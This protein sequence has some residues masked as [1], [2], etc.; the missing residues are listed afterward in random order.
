MAVA[1]PCLLQGSPVS[2]HTCRLSPSG[3]AAALT[4]DGRGS[5]EG[6]HPLVSS[7]AGDRWLSALAGAFRYSFPHVA[8]SPSGRYL[9]AVR[10]PGDDG[11]HHTHDACSSS[12]ISVLVFDAS[13]A[14]WLPQVQVHALGTTS[15]GG[16]AEPIGPLIWSCPGPPIFSPCETLVATQVI[17]QPEHDGLVFSLL[18]VGVHHAF[19][20]VLVSDR[21]LQHKWLPGP[22]P[23]PSLV[24]L[25]CETGALARADL[26]MHATASTGQPLEVDWHPPACTRQDSVAFDVTL[27]TIVLLQV[28]DCGSEAAELTFSVY[29]PDLQQH[30]STGAITVKLQGALGAELLTLGDV[31]GLSLDVGLSCSVHL[32]P[33]AVAA[34]CWDQEPQGP[35]HVYVFGLN[36]KAG[37]V[38]RHLFSAQGPEVEQMSLSFS[39]GGHFLAIT[40]VDAVCVLDA[41]TGA[42]LQRLQPCDFSTSLVLHRHVA[43]AG[44]HGD[45]LHVVA[46]VSLDPRA[47]PGVLFSIVD[48]T[49]AEPQQD[50]RFSAG[51]SASSSAAAAEE[52]LTDSELSASSGARSILPACSSASRS[53]AAAGDS[54]ASS[55]LLSSSSASSSIVNAGDPLA[56]SPL[57]ASYSPSSSAVADVAAGEPATDPTLLP[58]NSARSSAVAAE[59]PQ[60]DST[61]PASSP[62]IVHK[63]TRS[64]WGGLCLYAVCAVVAV[65]VSERLGS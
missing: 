43:W 36:C 38:C 49:K 10:K 40:L 28:K 58:S 4:F 50:S 54:L 17:G 47:H 45:R 53:G 7:P 11:C 2:P 63:P 5:E 41:R 19:A 39:P 27:D 65:V 48:V 23:I 8:Y 9:A 29:G 52:A 30:A 20:R 60:P 51:S 21:P 32:A 37:E 55:T 46:S 31:L 6:C 42:C 15:G 25:D 24:M 62:A 14:G 33:H 16:D 64:R 59:E 3:Q 1:K 22:N 13:V 12:A 61:L 56:D 34:L 44:S 26:G 57:L 35:C 18:I